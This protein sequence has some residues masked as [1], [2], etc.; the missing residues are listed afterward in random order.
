M[1]ISYEECQEKM[2]KILEEKIEIYEKLVKNLK[3]Q[4][5][6]YKEITKN[7]KRRKKI[8]NYQLYISVLGALDENAS[9]EERELAKVLLNELYKTSVEGEN[10]NEW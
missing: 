3:E 9:K 1:S 6:Y 10:E 2:I 4:I 7:L 5:K 8:N